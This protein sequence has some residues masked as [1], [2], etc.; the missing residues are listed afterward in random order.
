MEQR[1]IYQNDKGG[2]S[3]IVPSDCG[4]TIEQIAEKDVPSGK[5]Y[6]IVNMADIPV[7]RGERNRFAKTV[8]ADTWVAEKV[9]A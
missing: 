6:K 1:I 9:A 2:V 5:P 4:L 8:M 7:D 3:V